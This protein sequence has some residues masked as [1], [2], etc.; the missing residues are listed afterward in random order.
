MDRFEIHFD[1]EWILT[2]IVIFWRLNVIKRQI[3]F[4][5]IVR[6]VF[7]LKIIVFLFKIFFGE[8]IWVFHEIIVMS[9]SFIWLIFK[10]LIRLKWGKLLY[11]F[12]GTSVLI[13]GLYL[14]F[15]II[16]FCR[17]LYSMII[18][19]MFF[20]FF[21]W[22]WWALGFRTRNWILILSFVNEMRIFVIQEGVKLF[23]IFRILI[24]YRY[25]IFFS[26]ISLKSKKIFSVFLL[27]LIVLILSYGRNVW[28]ILH[29]QK[30]WPLLFVPKLICSFVFILNHKLNIL[31]FEFCYS[32]ILLNIPKSVGKDINFTLK[33]LNLFRFLI[34]NVKFSFQLLTENKIFLRKQLY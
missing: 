14:I 20:F 32:E 26:N 22:I 9:L 12:W 29:H 4:I 16:A 3:S 1:L 33:L 18:F 31:L 21:P 5:F 8:D 30:F 11:F 13:L 24:P 15:K 17:Q 2:K 27:H 10:H 6:N 23:E 19:K 28:L 25:D 7:I 34:H